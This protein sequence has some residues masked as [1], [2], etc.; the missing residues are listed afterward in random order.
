MKIVTQFRVALISLATC[1]GV[2]AYAAFFVPGSIMVQVGASFLGMVIMVYLVI[3]TYTRL[4][5][6]FAMINNCAERVAKG[7]LTTEMCYTADDELG[8][9]VK[10]YGK[11][12]G[13]LNSMLL[14]VIE[15]AN[16]IVDIVDILL[17]R[18]ERT[19]VSAQNQSSRSHQIAT[20]AEEMSQTI[21]DIAK[22]ATA[23]SDTSSAALDAA[24]RGNAVAKNSGETVERVFEA[25]VDL[26]SMVEKLNS[27]VGE[28]SGIATVI[29]GIAD[30][31]NLLA[32]NAAIEAARAGEQGRGF[33]VVADEVRKLAE[34]TIKATEEISEKITSVQTE[35]QQTMQSMEHASSEVVQAKSEIKKV[36]EALLSI[37]DSVQRARDQITH[38]ATSV[39]EQSATTGE[40]ATNIEQTAAI[41]KDMEKM[42]S[43]VSRDVNTLISVVEGIRNAAGQFFIKGAELM[44]LDRART[45]HL[46]FMEKI[47]SHLQGEAHLD[48]S[49]LTDHHS[50]RFGK[51]YDGD[52]KKLCG[53]LASYQAI[54]QPHARI[55]ALAKNAV[56]DFNAGKPRQAEATF[57]EMKKLS[58]TIASNL[59]EIK[60]ES[61]GA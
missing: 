3:M 46:L 27:R 50:C 6:P 43:E 44:I 12:L 52:G 9:M 59:L 24:R 37:V 58:E 31:T 33:A 18:S 61:S 19:S 11:M 13:S 5:R 29:K 35:S 15:S 57:A 47:R 42:S 10:N 40:V 51:W 25:T 1:A 8:T 34:R 22:N 17:N 45:D 23:S 28:I 32:L 38:I 30:Q 60:R 2:N 48:S 56:S 4:A 20:A 26:A 36:G 39:E 14:T 41:A 7:D 55:H 16:K 21:I 49:Q 53:G 54:D